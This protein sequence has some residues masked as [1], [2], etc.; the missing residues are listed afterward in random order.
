MTAHANPFYVQKF[1]V[2]LLFFTQTLYDAVATSIWRKAE[3]KAENKE[4]EKE[5]NKE[6]ERE[7]ERESYRPAI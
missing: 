6:T 5:T 4:E 7:R 2:A 1:R 3:K